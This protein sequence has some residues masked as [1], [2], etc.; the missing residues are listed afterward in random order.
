MVKPAGVYP[1]VIVVGRP[2]LQAVTLKCAP[3]MYAGLGGFASPEP[4]PQSYEN[5]S[6]TASGLSDYTSSDAES[7]D[8]ENMSHGLLAPVTNTSSALLSF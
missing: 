8:E 1:D 3:A 5:E 6:T 4:D 7:D 2:C